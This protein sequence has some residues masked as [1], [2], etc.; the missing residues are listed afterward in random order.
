MTEARRIFG[1]LWYNKLMPK[2]LVPVMSLIAAVILLVMLNFT[3]PAGIGPLGVLVFFTTFYI[4]MF[5]IALG[6]VKIV[7]KILG[8][9]F[10]RKA[11][12]YGAIVA[13]GP[14]MLMLAQA[15]GTMSLLTFALT[16]IFVMLG[17]LLISKRMQVR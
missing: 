5:G 4:L 14:I 2:R 11:P 6:L 3:T 17:C 9:N 8:K 10:G 16:V 1:N 7:G 13:F 15:L 12:L